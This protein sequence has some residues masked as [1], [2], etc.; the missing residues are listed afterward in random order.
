MMLKH[1]VVISTGVTAIFAIWVKSWPGSLACFLSGIFIDLDHNLDYMLARKELPISYRKLIDFLKNDHDTK[2]H[3]FLHSY[4]M[5]AVL[6]I[7]IFTFDLNVIWLGIA[8]GITT[9]MICDE[10][11]NPFRPLAYFFTYR[12]T[13][14]FCRKMLFKKDHIGGYHEDD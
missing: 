14:G 10:F 4:E 3:L 12:F 5:H 1:H 6:W 9:H 7:C 13:H 11:Y 2:L 8:V